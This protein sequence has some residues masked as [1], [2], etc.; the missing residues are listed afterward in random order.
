MLDLEDTAEGLRLDLKVQ[1]NARRSGW[2]GR[3]GDRLKVAL[4]APPVDGK[5][6]KALIEFLANFASISKSG[7]E[8]VRGEASREKTL[9]LRGLGAA[10]MQ[11][12]LKDA[13]VL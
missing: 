4:T 6:N 2:A 11:E 10:R 8:I 9:L 5:A 3:H 12:L 13:G 1:P 7:I